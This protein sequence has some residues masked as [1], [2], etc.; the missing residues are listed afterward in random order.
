[1]PTLRAQSFFSKLQNEAQNRLKSVQIHLIHC[2]EKL[3]IY[4]SRLA[5]S[6]NG[7]LRSCE[8]QSVEICTLYIVSSKNFQKVEKQS[9]PKNGQIQ[10]C[11]LVALKAP[12]RFFVNKSRAQRPLFSPMVSS[13]RASQCLHCKHRVFFS[14]L[15]NQAQN[16]LKKRSNRSYSL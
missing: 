11:S 4:F 13:G 5:P 8:C 9:K 14:K 15:Q 6:G 16:R 2:N 3:S 10:F 12:K 7:R 1:M